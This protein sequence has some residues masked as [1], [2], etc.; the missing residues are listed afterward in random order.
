MKFCKSEVCNYLYRRLKKKEKKSIFATFLTLNKY[1]N[2][3]R[4]LMKSPKLQ[5]LR[6][7]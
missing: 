7:Q 6:V 1:L 4:V 2:F 5:C 3:I